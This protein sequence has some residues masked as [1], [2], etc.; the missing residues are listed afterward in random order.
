MLIF[1]KE[2]LYRLIKGRS[3]ADRSRQITN[4]KMKDYTSTTVALDSLLLTAAIDVHEER[5]V[6]V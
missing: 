1:L 4:I 6:L 2:K 5:D 3:C